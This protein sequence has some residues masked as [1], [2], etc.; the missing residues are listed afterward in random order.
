[1]QATWTAAMPYTTEL[2][3][4]QCEVSAGL[5]MAGPGTGWC[6]ITSLHRRKLWVASR[7]SRDTQQQLDEQ[8]A[9]CS[10]NVLWQQ[11]FQALIA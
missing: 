2:A 8:K 9:L 6:L 3:I 11:S 4:A 10:Q 5:F 1:M 7:T